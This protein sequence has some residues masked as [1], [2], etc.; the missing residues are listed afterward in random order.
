MCCM[1]RD[2]GRFSFPDMYFSAMKRVFTLLLRASLPP[3]RHS[4]PLRKSITVLPQPL[5]VGISL[6][7]TVD[8]AQ[9]VVLTVTAACAGGVAVSPGTRTLVSI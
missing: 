1:I 7:R 2:S 3:S 5:L 9:L 8:G 4:P 6:N